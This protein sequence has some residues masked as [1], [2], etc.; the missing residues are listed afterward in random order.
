MSLL[1]QLPEVIEQIGRDIKAITVVLGS[2]RPDKPETT[3]GKITGDEPN[4]T[5]YESSDGGGVGA[6]KWQKRDKKWVVTD[7]DTGLVNAVTKNLKPG[8]YIKLRRQGN[9]VTCHMGGLSWGCLVIW[10]RPKKVIAHDKQ[11]ELRLSVKGAFLVA[12]ELMTLVD[13]VCLMT[14]PTEQLQVFMWEVWAIQILC[15]LPHT[16]Q[17][18]K[19]RG[20]QQSLI[21]GQIT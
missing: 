14:I 9:F 8:A 21:E 10:V 4:G 16:T 20:M 6:W 12:L 11:V 2:D 5:I 3:S 15:D 7:G 18:L 19:S 13:L 17:T 1:Q